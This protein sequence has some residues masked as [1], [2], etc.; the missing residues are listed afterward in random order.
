MENAIRA[1]DLALAIAGN[2]GV[3]RNH[4]LER[5]HRNVICG[6]THAPTGPLVRAAAAKS[7][8]AAITQAASP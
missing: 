1:V 8:I 4:A 7:A 6:R 2:A 3:S 5:H